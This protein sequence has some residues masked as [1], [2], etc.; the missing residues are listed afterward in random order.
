M[1]VEVNQQRQRQQVILHKSLATK[2]GRAPDREEMAEGEL[3]RRDRHGHSQKRKVLPDEAR[4]WGR[5][6]GTGP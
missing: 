6:A 4:E 5:N 3:F 1:T 2:K